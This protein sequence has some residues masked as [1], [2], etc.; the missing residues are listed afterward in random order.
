MLLNRMRTMLFCPANQPKN[1]I[2]APVF[3][4]DCII[5]DLED[6]IPLTEKD[7]ARDLLSEAITA[8][9]FGDCQVYARINSLHT[10]FGETDVRTIVPA[11]IHFLRLA[12]CECADDVRS[13]S[14]LLDEVEQESGIEPNSVKIQCSIETARGVLN[15][16]ET[17]H[18]STRVISLSFGAE[19]Y[20]RSMGTNCSLDGSELLY[21]R[22]YLP[23]VAAEAGITAVDTVWSDL[24]NMKGFA[25]EVRHAKALGFS[26]KSCIHPSQISIVNDIFTPSEREVEYARRVLSAMKEAQKNGLGVFTVDGKMVDEPVVKK[27]QHILIQAGEGRIYDK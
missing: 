27:A 3:H 2:N 22:T 25:E 23:V 26:G 10:P 11:G 19:D 1:Y 4:P 21:A 5:F 17:V 6:A 24:E 8:L 13:L 15:A 16:R 20:T 9:P 12:M 18:A 14:Q 7:S